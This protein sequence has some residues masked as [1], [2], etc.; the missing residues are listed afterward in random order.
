MVG[1]HRVKAHPLGSGARL[2]PVRDAAMERTAPTRCHEAVGNVA[3]DPVAKRVVFAAVDHRIGV[4]IG[5]HHLREPHAQVG[6]QV[7]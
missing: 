5:G 4:D 2:D 6:A 7:S 1:E 3:G